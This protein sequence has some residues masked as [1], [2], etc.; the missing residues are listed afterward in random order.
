MIHN[1]IANT[2]R[3]TKHQTYFS[4]LVNALIIQESPEK[5][6]KIHKIIFMKLQNALGKHIVMIPQ[7]I[8]MNASHAI[9]QTGHFF[10]SFVSVVLVLV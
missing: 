7:R 3:T 4:S 8:M 2:H 10:F 6:S 9:N 5:T 1:I